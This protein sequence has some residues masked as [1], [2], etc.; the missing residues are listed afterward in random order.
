MSLAHST[1]LLEEMGATTRVGCSG[2]VPSVQP[3]SGLPLPLTGTDGYMPPGPVGQCSQSRGTRRKTALEAK[4][5]QL[6]S[7]SVDRTGHLGLSSLSFWAQIHF[8]KTQIGPFS[9]SGALG[10]SQLHISLHTHPRSLGQSLYA[11]L[12]LHANRVHGPGPLASTKAWHRRGLGHRLQALL[13]LPDMM[14]LLELFHHVVF[15]V[16][17]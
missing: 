11:A 4:Y 9:Q 1:P 2:A 6:P 12:L 7:A 16:W 17:V 3:G 5:S 10:L 15:E 8:Q 14:E 13:R